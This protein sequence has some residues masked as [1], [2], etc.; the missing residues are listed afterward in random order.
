[1]ADEE[2]VEMRMPKCGA[3]VIGNCVML[4]CDDENEAVLLFEMLKE[5]DGK[6]VTIEPLE[7]G[8]V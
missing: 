7:E 5:M 1:M 6:R 3:S 2:Y 8:N 4:Q